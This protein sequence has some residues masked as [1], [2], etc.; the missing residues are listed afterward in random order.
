M[1]NR[2]LTPT[3][4]TSIFESAPKNLNI[5]LVSLYLGGFLLSITFITPILP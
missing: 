4:T 5:R 1:F 2:Y 3:P